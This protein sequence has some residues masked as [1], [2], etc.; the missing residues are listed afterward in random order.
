[1]LAML[2]DNVEVI[3]RLRKARRTVMSVVG[4]LIRGLCGLGGG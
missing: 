1:M 3:L 4:G 2:V